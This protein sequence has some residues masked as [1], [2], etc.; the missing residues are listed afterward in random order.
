MTILSQPRNRV[1]VFSRFYENLPLCPY[2][3]NNFKHGIRFSNRDTAIKHRYIQPNFGLQAY[4]CFDLDYNGASWL[5]FDL[6]QPTIETATVGTGHC[7]YLYELEKPI[8]LWTKAHHRPIEYAK[9]ISIAYTDHLRADKGY[10]GLLTKNPLNDHWLTRTYDKRYMLSELAEYVDLPSRS[11]SR[12]PHTDRAELGRN[13]FLFETVRFE[14]YRIARA[15]K[16]LES[17]EQTINGIVD[18][19]NAEHFKDDLLPAREC[20]QIAYS[21]AKWTWERRHNFT[22]RRKIYRYDLVS[23]RLTNLTNQPGGD[24]GP[25]WIS[26]ALAVFPAGKMTTLWA[27]LKQKKE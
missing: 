18:T 22:R 23:R 19:L 26:G 15:H 1:N 21:I 20:E 24:Y 16:S 9:A 14:A 6:P 10:T 25:H 11:T 2:Y 27:Q 8:F 12:P 17:L 13:C 7:H 3:T 4:L 5:D